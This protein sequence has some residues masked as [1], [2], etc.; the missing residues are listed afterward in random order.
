MLNS[1]FFI[2]IYHVI[3]HKIIQNDYRHSLFEN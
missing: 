3:C 2:Y 1:R